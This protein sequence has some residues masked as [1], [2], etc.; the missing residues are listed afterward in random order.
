MAPH[1]WVCSLAGRAAG[2]LGPGSEGAGSSITW[3][4]GTRDYVDSEDGRENRCGKRG[5]SKND[6]CPMSAPDL[7]LSTVL[8]EPILTKHCK[9]R[10]YMYAE[11]A[12]SPRLPPFEKGG[13]GGLSRRTSSA[14]SR[15]YESSGKGSLAA[16]FSQWNGGPDRLE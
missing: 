15:P 16:G 3:T 5:L 6:G 7:E 2:E 4:G 10:S 12:F 8:I 11:L 9:Q 1:L 14:D 13:L